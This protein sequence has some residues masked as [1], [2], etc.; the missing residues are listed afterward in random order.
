VPKLVSAALLAF[1]LTGC[2]NATPTDTMSPAP[3]AAGDDPYL[4]E[5]TT[6]S[7][8]TPSTSGPL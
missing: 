5:S 7:L 3:T 8:S 4:P 1:V 2:M 6:P